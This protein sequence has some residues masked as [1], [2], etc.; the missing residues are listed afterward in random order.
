MSHHI[1]RQYRFALVSPRLRMGSGAM[2]KLTIATVLASLLLSTGTIIIATSAHTAQLETLPQLKPGSSYAQSRYALIQQGWR[3]IRLADSDKCTLEINDE[4]TA[5]PNGNRC[6]P[7]IRACS[8]TGRGYCIFT[9][10]KRHTIISVQTEGEPP[11]IVSVEHCTGC[12]G[13]QIKWH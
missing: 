9:W 12:K 6:F 11:Q 4:T 2:D 8:G 10:W 13:M 1:K 3:P 5:S 7:E